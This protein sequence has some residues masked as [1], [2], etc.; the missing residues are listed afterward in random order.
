M[1]HTTCS[2]SC[3]KRVSTLSNIGKISRYIEA[4][5]VQWLRQGPGMDPVSKKWG[6]CCDCWFNKA[7]SARFAR[8]TRKVDFLPYI[9]L[10]S[11]K[12]DFLTNGYFINLRYL[13]LVTKINF[14]KIIIAEI[15]IEIKWNS[16]YNPSTW[17][18][19]HH[20]GDYSINRA[21]H[22]EYQWQNQGQRSKNLIDNVIV[23][24]LFRNKWLVAKTTL[25]EIF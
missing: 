7:R 25:L 6:G 1:F 13:Y 12:Y 4:G 8:L 17:S 24:I 2:F 9:S 11:L 18:N 22:Q 23:K 3:L 15:A 19:V 14:A 5:I 21:A 20:G 10:N 16:F